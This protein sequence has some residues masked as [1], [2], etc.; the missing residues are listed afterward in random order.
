MNQV[1][2]IQVTWIVKDGMDV[3]FYTSSQIENH[4]QENGNR[5]VRFRLENRNHAESEDPFDVIIFFRDQGNDIRFR[6]DCYEEDPSAEY[7][8]TAF[9]SETGEE[10]ILL[11]EDEGERIYFHLT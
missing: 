2:D 11:C 4:V 6:A 5:T 1:T 9:V 8:L 7:P 10:T 3:S